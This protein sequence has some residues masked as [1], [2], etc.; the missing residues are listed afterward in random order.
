M[1]S[2]KKNATSGRLLK[3]PSSGRLVKGCSGGYDGGCRCAEGHTCTHCGSDCTPNP[4]YVTFS[5]VTMCSCV[6][7]GSLSE[8]FANLTLG[9]PYELAQVGTGSSSTACLWRVTPSS[10]DAGIDHRNYA[11]D[12]CSGAAAG[13][14]RR[15][16]TITLQRTDPSWVLQVQ[17]VYL[18][19]PLLFYD[20]QPE[21]ADDACESFPSFANDK[22]SSGDCAYGGGLSG[23]VFAHSGTATLDCDE[24]V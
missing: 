20:V 24:G 9:G 4:I 22:S 10:S 6:N 23:G 16:L 19:D 8:D 17:A 15:Q 14:T 5:G 12:D 18:G 21:T 11:N 3:H 13:D 1:T 7:N 2:L